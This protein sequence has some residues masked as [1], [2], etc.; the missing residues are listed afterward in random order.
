MKIGFDFDKV[1]V[2]FPP[3]VPDVLI[4]YLY[5]NHKKNTRKKS[6]YRFPG[7]IEQQIRI[8]SHLPFLRRPINQNIEILKHLSKKSDVQM[9]LVSS[10]F[11]FLE[12][13]T[14]KLLENYGLKQYFKGLYFNFNDGQPHE[15]KY[16]KIR[17]LKLDYYVDDDLDLLK[18]LLSKKMKTKL[19]WLD[20]TPFARKK[21]IPSSIITIHTLSEILPKLQYGK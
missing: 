19:F 16:E 10:R 20:G 7:K 18:Y 14:E 13:R 15:F 12:Q 17:A 3:L 1:F 21:E 11:S 4:D 8:A 6:I 5:K 9:Y 2:N